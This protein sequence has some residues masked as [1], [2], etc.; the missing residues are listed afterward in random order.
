[1][2]HAIPAS[3]MGNQCIICNAIN[4]GTT[5]TVYED[6]EIVALIDENP[7]ALGQIA[8]MPKAHYP[9][10]EQVPDYLINHMFQVVNKI[11]ISV[12]EALQAQG[13]N[14]LVSN[15]VAAGQALPHFMVNIIPRRENDG[16]NFQWQ[17][18]QLSEEEMSTVELVLKEHT[19]LINTLDVPRPPSQNIP[20]EQAGQEDAESHAKAHEQPVEEEI[21]GENY[22]IKQLKRRA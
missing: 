8:I 22:L 5:L 19:Q 13:T 10:I 20:A 2:N 12:F 7:A 11:S 17:T 21:A 14:L 16:L 3:Q 6:N 15:G 9:I 18:K 4:S 1:M